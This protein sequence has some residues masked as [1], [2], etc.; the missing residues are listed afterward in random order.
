VNKLP[1]IRVSAT[2]L[3]FLI[4]VIVAMTL[5]SETRA[6]GPTTLLQIT[7]PMHF[8]TSLDTFIET[9][10]ISTTEQVNSVNFTIN[11]NSTLLDVVTVNQGSFFPPSF[12]PTYF[13]YTQDSTA[14]TITIDV[15]LLDPQ[16]QTGNGTL[17]TVMFLPKIDPK[18]FLFTPITLSQILILNAVHLPLTYDTLNAMCFWEYLPLPAPPATP[19]LVDVYTQKSGTGPNTYGGAFVTDTMVILFAQATYNAYPVQ[20][21][22]VAFQILDSN[23]Q[24]IA[25]LVGMTDENGTAMTQFRI[26]SDL[27]IQGTWWA[28]ASVDISC[29][30]VWD[31]VNFTVFFPIGGYTTTTVKTPDPTPQYITTIIALAAAMTLTKRKPRKK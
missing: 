31:T 16:T 22:P 18:S 29:T 19:R 6:T 12:P 4:I 15:E 28:I 23:N 5:S 30:I 14:G 10:T 3:A 25:I 11:Y 1:R 24:T 7:P 21:I 26:R 17:A 13:T 9:V 2:A 27:S 20:N 8:V